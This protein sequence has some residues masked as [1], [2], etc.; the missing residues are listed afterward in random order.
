MV[1]VQIRSVRRVEAK[2]AELEARKYEVSEEHGTCAKSMG[3]PPPCSF[4]T[5]GWVPGR[6]RRSLSIGLPVVGPADE[7][8]FLV[9]QVVPVTMSVRELLRTAPKRR[10][11][12]EASSRLGVSGR[13]QRAAIV[14][15]RKPRRRLPTIP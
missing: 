7:S 4:Y 13:T 3:F 6:N 9:P 12:L 14:S 8:P 15:L 10:T 2:A 5:V 11:K 1:A